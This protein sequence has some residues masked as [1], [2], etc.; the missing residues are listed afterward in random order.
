MVRRMNDDLREVA[1]GFERLQE[2][3]IELGTSELK[4]PELLLFICVGSDRA[5]AIR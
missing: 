5:P 4:K 2:Y 1:G 3:S